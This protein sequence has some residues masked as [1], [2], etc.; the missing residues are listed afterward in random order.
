MTMRDHLVVIT[1]SELK[2]IDDDVEMHP[3]KGV[4]KF[5]YTPYHSHF[6]IFTNISPEE[7]AE[8]THA[9]LVWES[10]K[11]GKNGQRSCRLNFNYDLKYEVFCTAFLWRVDGFWPVP[12]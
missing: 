9:T 6:D 2:R 3:E 1:K 5:T 11:N 7:V 8:L 4:F 12:E 10:G